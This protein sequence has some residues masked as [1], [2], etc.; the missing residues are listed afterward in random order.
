MTWK[1]LILMGLLFFH[2]SIEIGKN[3]FVTWM[4]GCDATTTSVMKNFIF[5]SSFHQKVMQHVHT[6]LMKYILAWEF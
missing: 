2:S 5:V 3:S 4:R 6:F 1:R